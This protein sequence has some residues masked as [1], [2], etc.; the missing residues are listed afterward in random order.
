MNT[1]AWVLLGAAMGWAGF[2]SLKMNRGRSVLISL[3]VGGIGGYLGG[4][5]I[6]PMFANAASA[7]EGFSP[8]ALM[9]AGIT[10]AACLFVSDAIYERY[11]L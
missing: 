9:L 11:G 1:A 5:L 6:S 2:A 10:A 4:H 8:F 7:G 3:L